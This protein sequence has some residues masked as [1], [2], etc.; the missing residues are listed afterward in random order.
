MS[1]RHPGTATKRALPLLALFAA[2]LVL[3]TGCGLTTGSG[4]TDGAKARPGKSSGAD[5]AAHVTP[6]DVTPLLKP[7]S[8]YLGVA[9]DG[10]PTSLKALGAYSKRI[11]KHPNALEYYAA[12][13]DGF[14]TSG[15]RR[16]YQA[17]AL[18]FMAWEPFKPSLKAI[19]AGESDAY[20]KKM[21]KD[22]VGLNLPIAISFGHEMNGDWYAWGRTKATPA[23]YV[24]AWRHIHDIF[25][26]AGATNVI[27]VWTPNV[28]NPMPNVDLKQ[29]YPGDA[30]VDWA[31]MI[32]Y[33]TLTGADTFEGLYGPTMREIRTFTKKPIF[34]A[35]TAAQEGQRRRADVNDLFDGVASHDDVI[36]FIWF[37]IPKRADWRIEISPLALAEYR[38]RAQASDF[39][40][41]IR[42]QQ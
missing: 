1:A 34:I 33:Y 18:P 8:K 10:V 7:K 26:D 12:F 28:I 35:E 19:A 30:Y 5:D 25:Q 37:N 29:Y 14:D 32:G 38:R 16:I 41:D 3:V 15:V 23:D 22:I 11:G 6:Y 27:W 31:G 36:G 21:A 39:G 17:G 9:L 13:G 40:F 42:K 24:A 4:D 20:V 2:C